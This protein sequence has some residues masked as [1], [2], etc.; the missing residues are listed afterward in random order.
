MY[1][2]VPRKGLPV[3]AAVRKQTTSAAHFVQKQKALQ[4]AMKEQQEGKKPLPVVITVEEAPLAPVPET[5]ALPAQTIEWDEEMPKRD[6]YLLAKEAGLDVRS[7]DSKA[8]ILRA[9]AAHNEKVGS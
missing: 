5:E 3:H 1:R 9:I 2:I 6:L 7:K 8:K 4:E